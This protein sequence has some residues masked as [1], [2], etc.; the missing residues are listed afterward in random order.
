MKQVPQFRRSRASSARVKPIEPHCPVE[1]DER[2]DRHDDQEGRHGMHGRLE[3]EARFGIDANRQ[4]YGARGREEAGDGHLSEA[5][6]KRD[7]ARCGEAGRE[8]GDD[9]ERKAT[10]GSGPQGGRGLLLRAVELLDRGRS[11]AMLK[12][13]MSTT[14]TA[15]IPRNGGT[16]VYSCRR[17]NIPTPMATCGSDKGSA[18]IAASTMRPVDLWRASAKA[19]GIAKASATVAETSAISTDSRNEST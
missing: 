7:D 14:C 10:E 3:A 19:A 18:Q 1:R 11:K 5:Q 4:C 6:Q 15:T 12:G 8:P 16:A 17:R 13:R 2:H 9:H